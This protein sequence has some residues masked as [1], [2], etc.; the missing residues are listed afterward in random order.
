MLG[1][2]ELKATYN[3]TAKE[4]GNI[5]EEYFV[6][7]ILNR[8]SQFKNS[9]PKLLVVTPPLVDEELNYKQRGTNIYLGATKKSKDLN[10]I[11]KKYCRKI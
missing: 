10:D 8:K 4:I 11:Y 2:N 6:K 7:T 9:Y 3:K 5:L 1:T